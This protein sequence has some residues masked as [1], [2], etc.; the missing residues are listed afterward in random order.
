MTLAL[1]TLIL[2]ANSFL[3]LHRKRPYYIKISMSPASDPID[4]SSQRF[5]QSGFDLSQM[6]RDVIES[7]RN[8]LT[9]ISLDILLNKDTEKSYSGRFVSGERY[10]TK[11]EGVYVCAIG[12]LPLFRS[13][14]KFVS[15]TGWPS[16]Y[17]VY[18]PDHIKEIVTP[19]TK[20]YTEIRC[21][22]SGCHI[23]HCYSDHPPPALQRYFEANGQTKYLEKF[24]FVRYCVNAGALVLVRDGFENQYKNLWL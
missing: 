18:D 8:Q 13:S 23:G 12:G 4:A 5:S 24:G 1:L 7:K 2:Y 14:H 17:D 11:E 9:N 21:R 6:P 15:G 16:F 19:D 3:F 10:N 22:R 20:G